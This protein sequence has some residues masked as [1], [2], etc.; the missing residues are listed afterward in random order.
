MACIALDLKDTYIHD[1]KVTYIRAVFLVSKRVLA[2]LLAGG[3]LHP[4]EVTI[5]LPIAGAE[6][7][8]VQGTHAYTIVGIGRCNSKSMVVRHRTA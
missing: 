6:R 2:N 5:C 8:I 4:T 1:I 7:A 3:D